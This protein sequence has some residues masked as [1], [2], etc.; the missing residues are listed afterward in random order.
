[1]KS[2]IS[3]GSSCT[4]A[5]PVTVHPR[6][7]HP[8]RFASQ[9]S[10]TA[11]SGVLLVCSLCSRCVVLAQRCACVGLVVW[12]LVS[13][14]RV[15]FKSVSSAVAGRGPVPQILKAMAMATPSKKLWKKSPSTMLN[16][17]A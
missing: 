2:E 6:S 8:T 14:F 12:L 5:D 1:M 4:S 15:C 17:I 7:A 13:V 3:C 9:R 11:R 16:T 10:S